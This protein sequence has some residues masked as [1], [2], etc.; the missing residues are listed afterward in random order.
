MFPCKKWPYFILPTLD[1]KPYLAIAF[2][3]C[4]YY[5]TMPKDINIY[6]FD[7]KF[8]PKGEI[9][10]NKPFNG[11]CYDSSE[12]C[13]WATESTRHNI[14]Y[15]L[16]NKLQE[17]DCIDFEN[18]RC[19][20]RQ[21]LGI[22]FDC[23]KNVLVVAFNNAICEISKTGEVLLIKSCPH[24]LNA[25]FIA[26]YLVVVTSDNKKQ[27]ISYYKGNE[28]VKTEIIPSVYRIRAIVYNPCILSLVILATK[29]CRYPRVI[30]C[31]LELETDCCHNIL[32][33]KKCKPDSHGDKC[34]IIESVA[35][36]ETALSHILNAEGEKLQKAVK[37]AEN[38]GELLEMNS[39][40]HK[41]LMLATQLEHVL[42][43]KLQVATELGCKESE[44]TELE[45][46]KELE[47]TEL[48]ECKKL[49]CMELEECKKLECIERECKKFEKMLSSG[50]KKE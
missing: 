11:L 45:E 35:K 5:L 44:C 39:S 14:I 23:V 17:I 12:D 42:Y 15:K 25:A 7:R 47:C 38:V 37:I 46:C 6:K 9:K 34:N 43:A 8:R 32:C 40:V 28:L 33:N 49:E 19:D 41:T 48:E 13:F 50:R 30:C 36:M 10:G 16:N 21:M 22:S 20:Y 4:F 26:P 18:T 1:D 2:D 24:I 31:P 27:C 29:H 3:G